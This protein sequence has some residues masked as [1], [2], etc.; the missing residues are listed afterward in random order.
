M[1]VTAFLTGFLLIFSAWGAQPAGAHPYLVQTEPGP[2]VALRDPPARIQIAFTERVVLE[3]SSLRLDDSDGRPLPLGPLGA[4]KQGPGLAADVKGALG[5]DVY[6]VRWVVLAEDGHSSS[7]DYRFG[8]DGPN[9]TPPKHAELL[10]PT[11]GPADQ[12]AASDGPARIAL[13][14]LGLLG[15]SLL[16]GGAVL[17]TRLRGRLG[18]EADEMV[19]ARWAAL[20]R[21]AW[22]LTLVASIAAVLGAAGAGAGGLQLA[23]LLATSTGVLAVA[24]L[25]GV[26]VAGLPG[27]FGPAGPRRDQFLGMAGAFF[28][29]AEAVGGHITAMTSAWRF[30][31]IVAQG[32]HLAAAAMWVGGLGVL[33]YAVAG[34]SAAA[35]PAVWRTAAA[36]F[37]P[38]A[39]ISAAVVIATGVIASVREVEHRYF[40]LWS[41][42]GRYLLGKW[43]L[44]V[45]M[46]VLGALAGR[47]L[48]RRARG[49]AGAPAVRTGSGAAAQ[50]QRVG[51][52]LRTEAVL[53]V[54]V[55]IFAAV[56]VGV[57]QGRGQ[58][59]PAQKGSVLAGPAFANA[60]VG[61]G[62]V[63]MALSPAAPGRNRLTALLANPVEAATAGGVQPSAAP[64]RQQA[65]VKVKLVCDCAAEPVD[66]GLTGSAG[67]WR[68]DLDLPEAGVWRASLTIGGGT[69]L[70]PVALRVATGDAPGASPYVISSI[71]DLSGPAARRCRSFQLGLVLSLAFLN[72]KG[73]VDGRKV[74]VRARDDGGDPA[75][76]RE[77]AE[78]E[79]DGRLAVPCGPTAA[80]TAGIQGRRGPVIVA[81]AL[82]PPVNGDRVF[83]LSGDPYAE[84]WAAGRTLARSGF[85]GRTD[86]PRRMA[87]VV[88][89]G[90][91]GADRIVAGARAALALDPA[92]A[93]KAEGKRPEST[94]DVEVVVLRHEPGTPLFPLVQEAAN[95]AKYTATFLA[96]DP[97]ALGSALDQLSDV[98]IAGASAML[99]ASRA[100]DET[101]LR[102]SKIGRRGDV[103][104]YGE[105]APDSGESLVY[106]RLVKT[107]FPGEQPTIDGLRGY[108][109]GKAIAL[110]LDKGSSVND[111]VAHLKVLTLFSDG[112]VSGWSPAAPAAGSW[113]FLLFKGSF[114]PSGLQP[115][116]SPEAG[117]FFAEGGAWSRVATGNVG[118]CG[119][120]LSVDGPPAPCETLARK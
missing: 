98:E 50:G 15:A 35:R 49:S 119:P 64:P 87:V 43:A 37:R 67:A 70:A 91:P 59:L 11:G 76:A 60:V 102:S 42:Y 107:I 46:L 32:A 24:R 25:V 14:W 96:A 51:G 74:V 2:G 38:V 66:A 116:A 44:V 83:R 6:R 40:L 62:L 8:V 56:L 103:K 71:G 18:D 111:L 112:V 3:G 12:S 20:A 48:G 17:L 84:G 65:S 117:R 5:G 47:T 113:R 100:F 104:I 63:R 90:D 41:A 45:A 7:G 23:V 92:E 34:V 110:A 22:T 55:L 28:L 108:M 86:A 36:A 97:A 75:R 73:G 13:R 78:G 19:T 52:L 101:F 69:S 39:A 106:T 114:I 81:D 120:Q 4:P 16:V 30:P 77:L 54:A 79:R 88:E 118:L 68:T 10:N 33:A 29:G 89:A 93:E 109:A 26:V 94:A 58:P 1:A 105:V 31:A 82:A 72:A 21:P 27:L 9:G 57:A 61:G 115:G 85:V 95:G 99:V 80:V 53:G